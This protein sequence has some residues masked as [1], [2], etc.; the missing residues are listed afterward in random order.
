MGWVKGFGVTGLVVTLL[1]GCGDSVCVMGFGKCDNPV[2]DPNGN[3]VL[4]RLKVNVPVER[5]VAGI[6]ISPKE[7]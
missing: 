5:A 4:G 2:A 7:A 6:K 1:V 3:P